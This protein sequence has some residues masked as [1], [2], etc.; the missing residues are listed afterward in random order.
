VTGPTG[1]V[2]PG[3][4]SSVGD[5]AKFQHEADLRAER[6][7][8][9]SIARHRSL[10]RSDEAYEK[11]LQEAERRVGRLARE[12]FGLAERVRKLEMDLYLASRGLSADGQPAET[13]KVAIRRKIA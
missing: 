6:G 1:N 13:L 12:N 5:W 3:Y 4:G 9:Y 10:S 2:W 8:L 11:R 7:V